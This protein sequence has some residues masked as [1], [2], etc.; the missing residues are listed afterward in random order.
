MNIGCFL[1]ITPR[2]GLLNSRCFSINFGNNL[3]KNKY[4]TPTRDLILQNEKLKEEIAVKEKSCCIE[5]PEQAQEIIHKNSN[6]RSLELLG[7]NKPGGFTTLHEKRNFFNRLNLD[8]THRHTK[9]YVENIDGD[10]ICYAATTEHYIAKRLHST[11][12]V[13]AVVNIAKILAQR[14]KQIGIERV[15]W[16]T[17]QNRTTEKMR[18]FEGILK[19]NGII[20]SELPTRIIQGPSQ[21]LPPP[22]K[23]RKLPVKLQCGTKRR[24]TIA[25]KNKRTDF[26]DHLITDKF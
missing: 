8:I 20:L 13:M 16:F 1:R 21:T 7:W 25:R 11:T 26:L 4:I 12:D 3:A 18:E 17:Y 24:G 15:H 22:R 23:E 5:D 9:A 10:I 19:N 6:P 14:L 2:V